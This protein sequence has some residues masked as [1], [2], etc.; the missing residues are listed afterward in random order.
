MPDLFKAVKQAYNLIHQAHMELD[1]TFLENEE[2]LKKLEILDDVWVDT[3]HWKFLKALEY[4]VNIKKTMN[5]IME[6]I[7]SGRKRKLVAAINPKLRQEIKKTRTRGR[8]PK[9][10]N[11]G[12]GKLQQPLVEKSTGS[13]R[14]SVSDKPKGSEPSRKDV[15]K[16]RKKRNTVPRT[17]AISRKGAKGNK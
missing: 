5:K 9:E 17:N 7:P 2:E 12:P 8:K 4:L 10:T 16:T 14:K 11:G 13:S 3:A 1:E 6:V 15:G